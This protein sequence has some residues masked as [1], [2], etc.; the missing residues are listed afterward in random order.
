MLEPATLRA[1]IDTCPLGSLRSNV[2][3]YLE[4]L[5]D[6]DCGGKTACRHSSETASN[7]ISEASPTLD[8]AS[9]GRSLAFISDLVNARGLLKHVPQQKHLSISEVGQLHREVPILFIDHFSKWLVPPK[10]VASLIDRCGF[11]PYLATADLVGFKYLLCSLTQQEVAIPILS[12]NGILSP[13]HGWNSIKSSVSRLVRSLFSLYDSGRADYLICIDLT[14]PKDI[15]NFLLSDFDGT[16]ARSK[17]CLQTFIKKVEVAFYGG[18]KLCVHENTHTWASQTPYEPHLHHHANFPNCILTDHGLVRV[19]PGF[20][21]G[22][23]PDLEKLELLRE[24]WK[25]SII[26]TFGRVIPIDSWNSNLFPH[27]IRLK[28]RAKLVHRLKY[29]ARRPMSDFF[30]WYRYGDPCPSER[31]KFVSCLFGFKNPRHHYGWSVGAM[32]NVQPAPKHVCPICHSEAKPLGKS[33][34]LDPRF[35][36]V[37]YDHNLWNWIPPPSFNSMD[38]LGGFSVSSA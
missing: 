20:F 23:K 17:R 30:E 18:A 31:L 7:A 12:P 27:Y 37:V 3:S 11:D 15:S 22:K 35:H 13:V 8:Y 33:Q 34:L 24:L 2:R 36:I 26:E 38:S 25:E 4:L 32:V 28:N 10:S 16:I 9:N 29:C 5:C 14:Y 21:K 6:S 1:S 19:Q